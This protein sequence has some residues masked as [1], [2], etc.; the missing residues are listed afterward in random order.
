MCFELRVCVQP[1]T[2]H[3]VRVHPQDVGHLYSTVFTRL[4]YAYGWVCLG[5]RRRKPR[6]REKRRRRSSTA[7]WRSM[8]GLGAAA[9]AAEAAMLAAAGIGTSRQGDTQVCV[10]LCR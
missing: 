1:S 3:L 5:L 2:I 10:V 8:L 7:E 9:R 4:L 6:P